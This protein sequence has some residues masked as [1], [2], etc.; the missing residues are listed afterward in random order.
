MAPALCRGPSKRPRGRRERSRTGRCRD[1]PGGFDFM[2][3]FLAPRN[4]PWRVTA[5]QRRCA[6][7]GGDGFRGLVTNWIFQRNCLR[8]FCMRDA[9]QRFG[10]V[11]QVKVEVQ[12]RHFLQRS[13]SE[14][15]VL[16][17]NLFTGGEFARGRLEWR[18]SSETWT[19]VQKFHGKR[20]VV[21]IYFSLSLSPSLFSPSLPLSPPPPDTSR[22]RG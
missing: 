15:N 7:G 18:V 12:K 13:S 4:C 5:S 22:P 9:C 17:E 1:W 2:Y 21:L 3:L 6:L 8:W 20:F 19:D 11:C 14:G 16:W 10:F